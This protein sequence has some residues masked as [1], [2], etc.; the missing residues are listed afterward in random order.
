MDSLKIN[1]KYSK[2]RFVFR[3]SIVTVN[4]KKKFMNR[5]LI[6]YIQTKRLTSTY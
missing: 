5:S 6:N 4:M 1:N 3:I 2:G